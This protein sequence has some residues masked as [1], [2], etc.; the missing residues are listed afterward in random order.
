MFNKSY[1]LSLSLSLSYLPDRLT[2]HCSTSVCKTE[3]PFQEW[4]SRLWMLFSNYQSS[5]AAKVCLIYF[6]KLRTD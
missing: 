5:K 1:S 6:L 4:Q 3:E 2:K